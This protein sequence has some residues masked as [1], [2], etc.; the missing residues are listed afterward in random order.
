VLRHLDHHPEQ[1]DRVRKTHLP[2][3][4]YNFA[5][6]VADIRAATGIDPEAKFTGLRHGGNTEGAD[7]GLSDAQ[8]RALSG[9]R[10]ANMPLIYARNTMKQ[11]RTAA[12]RR[13]EERSKRGK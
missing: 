12:R 7:A 6:R 10:S 3:T 2:W 11:R 4:R 5:H 9:H 13:L 8:L 1:P